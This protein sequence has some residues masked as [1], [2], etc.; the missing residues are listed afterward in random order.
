MHGF[1]GDPALLCHVGARVRMCVVRWRVW[2]SRERAAL[3]RAGHFDSHVLYLRCEELAVRFADLRRGTF[4]VQ[5]LDRTEAVPGPPSHGNV[6]PRHGQDGH[7]CN[8]A[9]GAGGAFCALHKTAP[10]N[11]RNKQPGDVVGR[12]SNPPWNGAAKHVRRI[13]REVQGVQPARPVAR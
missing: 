10:L 7:D 11:R 2:V 12:S 6:G 3:M 1:G 4:H 9:A 5:Q 8:P 13:A